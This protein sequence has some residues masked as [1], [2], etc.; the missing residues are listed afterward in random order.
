MVEILFLV[1]SLVVLFNTKSCDYD[2]KKIYPYICLQL[3]INIALNHYLFDLISRKT[4]G[5]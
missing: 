1:L 5:Q 4:N 3:L 2:K